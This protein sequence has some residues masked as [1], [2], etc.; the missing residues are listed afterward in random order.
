MTIAVSPNGPN[1]YRG[2]ASPSRVLVATTG[3]VAIVERARPG[4]AWRVAGR[5]LADKHVSSLLVEP[6]AG[7][8]FAGVHVGPDGGGGGL[9]FSADDGETWERRSAGLTVEHVFTLGSADT[10]GG[11]VIYAGTE[12][13]ALFRSRDYGRSWQELPAIRRVPG[14]DKWTFPPPP[15]LAHTK[16][17]SID[18][19]DPDIIFAAIEQGAL[20]KT[21]D[22]GATWR[23]LDSYDRPDD[24]WYRDIHR[25]VQGPA[26]PDEMFMTSGVGL[27]RSRDAGETWEHL[28]GMDFRV[29]YP[30]HLVVSP[31][32]D[33]MIF[34]AGAAR[35]PT[36]WRTT[37][38]AGG[39]VLRSRDSGRNWEPADRG[40]PQNG[41]ANIEAMTIAIHPGGFSLFV[42]NTDGEVYCSEDG[43][44]EWSL[45]VDGLA[46][47]SKV[48][49]FRNLQ[50]AHA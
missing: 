35:D 42:G 18:P 6:K 50:A 26:N 12:P 21:E 41:R 16:S 11:P 20:L 47:V 32:D 45:V 19:R 25:I 29:G 36:F 7:G 40:L 49:H 43:G 44:E 2:D 23:E 24:R 3:G 48:G 27:Y 28:T 46:P 1:V 9:Y 37:H 15:H 34:M 14:T 30:D 5:G 4:A 13:V 33:R 17:L 31:L 10:A 22:G 38:H 39:T 8:V